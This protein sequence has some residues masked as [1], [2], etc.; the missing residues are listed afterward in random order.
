MRG[1]YD[2]AVITN[3]I[4]TRKDA[5]FLLGSGVLTGE[6]HYRRGDRRLPP[7]GNT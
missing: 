3:D 7:F 5:D 2:F 6:P 4:Y 1:H